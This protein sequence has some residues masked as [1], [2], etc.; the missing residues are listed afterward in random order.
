MLATQLQHRPG[1][2]P[3][4]NV[5]P[6]SIHWPDHVRAARGRR[7]AEVDVAGVVRAR[8]DM[9]GLRQDVGLHREVSLAAADRTVAAAAQA[10]EKGRGK[11]L[12]SVLAGVKLHLLALE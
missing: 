5:S 9:G 1:R 2:A 6:R 8:S 3:Q 11:S 12:V 10:V 4:T 7:S